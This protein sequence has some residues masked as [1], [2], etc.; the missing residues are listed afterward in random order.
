MVYS[1]YGHGPTALSLHGRVAPAFAMFETLTL[2]IRIIQ[3]LRRGCT[4]RVT[5]YALLATRVGNAWHFSDYEHFAQSSEVPED[6]ELQPVHP[7][8]LKAASTWP[9]AQSRGSAHIKLR[10]CDETSTKFQRF[11]TEGI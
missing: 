9:R 1:L 10:S 8:Q 5:S 6:V 11:G 2:T 3:S 7:H 4:A